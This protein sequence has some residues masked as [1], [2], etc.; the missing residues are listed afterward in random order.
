MRARTLATTTAVATAAAAVGAA[1]MLSRPRPLIEGEPPPL[2]PPL[3]PAR[4][5]TLPGRGELF[6]RELPGP[7]T[8]DAPTIV[9]L[10]GWMVTADVNYF[11][12]YEALGRVGRVIA[13]D[14][15]GHGRGMRPSRPFRL[16][17]AAD[18][19]AALLDALGTG[20]AVAVGYSMGG[21]IAQLLWRRRPDLVGGLVLAATSATFSGRARDRWIWRGMGVLQ[22]GLRLVPRRAWDGIVRAQADGR[23]PPVL[24]RLIHPD[25][26]PEV[27]DVLPWMMG[28]IERGDAEDLADAGRELGRYDAR[29]WVGGIDVPTAV[30]VTT[31]D[32]LVPPDRQRDLAA[33]IPDVHVIE[34]PCDHDA[35]V[36]AAEVF[37]PALVEAV[38]AVTR[39]APESRASRTW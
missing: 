39:T 12:A 19:V 7:G 25:T 9:L 11:Q 28:E 1:I 16:A 15:R 14:H 21:P 24:T 17:D 34:L 31:A 4:T 26:P 6:V 18:D 37:V 33:R 30:L 3:P 38:R 10:H 2:P 27:L 32:T 8:P 29:E 22:L 5:L 23:I 36:A 13:V 35:A 20:P